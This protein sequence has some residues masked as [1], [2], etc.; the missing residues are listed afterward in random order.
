MTIGGT[1]SLVPVAGGAARKPSETV[2]LMAA[3]N[4]TE[5]PQSLAI[6][7]SWWTSGKGTPDAAAVSSQAIAPRG[8]KGEKQVGVVLPDGPYS[9]SGKLISLRWKVELVANEELACAWEFVLAPDGA[10]L[11]LDK[12]ADAPRLR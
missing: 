3:W 2:E 9:F 8:P 4:L 7:L 12:I 1:L 5:T 6:L 10:E 11:L